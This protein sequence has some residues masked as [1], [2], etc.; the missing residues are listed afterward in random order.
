MLYFL[1]ALALVF[2][3]TAFIGGGPEGRLI[4]AV[5]MT[6]VFFFGVLAVG[7]RRHMMAWAITLAAI[8]VAGTWAN[9]VWP[10]SVP[11]EVFRATGLLF[12][13]F[14]VFQL[15]RFIA[16]APRVDLEVLCAALAA[17]L[18]VALLW[19]FAYALIAARSPDSFVFTAGDAAERTMV[20]FNCLYF[21]FVTLCTVGYGDI[22]PVSPAARLLAMMEA[23]V[24][25]LFTTVLI[26]RLVGH[27]SSEHGGGSDSAPVA[28]DSL[29]SPAAREDAGVR[30][31][32]R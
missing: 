3:S 24:G 25:M 29:P 15:L 12:V 9:H 31:S 11:P 16:L 5:L 23:V 10:N 21:S 13:G 1:I 2:V 19:A 6:V 7:G 18:T 27:Y 17:Y 4:E 30:G 20:G 14:I 32:S 26:A 8:A 22:V 28:P